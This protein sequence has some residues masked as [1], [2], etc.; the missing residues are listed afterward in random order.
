MK[1]VYLFKTNVS[2]HAEAGNLLDGISRKL[3]GCRVTFD[4]EDC[5]RVLRVES[6][7]GEI[8]TGRIRDFLKSHG[9]HIE[10]L[11]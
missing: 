1:K 6:T 4:L 2:D 7:N 10:D 3:P 9:Y 11:L 5:D 8:D